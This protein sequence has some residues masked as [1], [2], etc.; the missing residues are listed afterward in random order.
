LGL[1]IWTICKLTPG[2]IDIPR[3]LQSAGIQNHELFFSL[4]Y[5]YI[6]R[7]AILLTNIINRSNIYKLFWHV[8]LTMKTLFLYTCVLYLIHPEQVELDSKQESMSDGAS[9]AVVVKQPSSTGSNHCF[10]PC[11]ESLEIYWCGGL[12]EVANLPPSIKTLQISNCQSLVS[13]SGEVPS[14]EKLD[15]SSCQSLESLPTGPAHQAYSSLRF[16]RIRSCTCMKQLPPSL[17]Q[18]LDHLEKKY[19]DLH[20]LRGN[21][22]SIS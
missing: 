10:F 21:L 16:L 6:F 2:V 20:L 4:I 11:L 17:Q 9:T 14:L 1:H 8:T 3:L 12:I 18:R 5:S 15:V 19:L 7:W 13:L 22:Y